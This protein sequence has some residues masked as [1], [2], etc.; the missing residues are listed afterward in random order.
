MASLLFASPY[1]PTSSVS[2]PLSALSLLLSQ[3][4]SLPSPAPAVYL[5]PLSQLSFVLSPLLFPF[6]LFL[7]LIQFRFLLGSLFFLPCSFLLLLSLFLCLLRCYLIPL[8]LQLSILGVLDALFV[9]VSYCLK[10]VCCLV[11]DL[12]NSLMPI[13]FSK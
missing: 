8:L 3:S 9:C 6:V 7:L 10:S 5:Q 4:L 2:L 12:S 13:C 1:P 11:V